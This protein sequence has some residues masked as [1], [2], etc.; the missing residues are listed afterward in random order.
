MSSW[1]HESH[2]CRCFFSHVP[3]IEIRWSIRSL[4]PLTCI[5][6]MKLLLNLTPE[7]GVYIEVLWY[8]YMIPTQPSFQ[9][10]ALCYLSQR[11]SLER[12]SS[13]CII[14]TALHWALSTVS[15]SVLRIPALDTA[16]SKKRARIFSLHLLAVLCLMQPRTGFAFADSCSTISI[17]NEA[18]IYSNH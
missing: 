16:V 3:K 6:S 1:R 7:K 15:I 17:R 4:G 14:F 9:I 12:C 10:P 5:R 8:M 18:V 11:F 13:L 2:F